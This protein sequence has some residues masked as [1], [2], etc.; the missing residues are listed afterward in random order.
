[1][2]AAITLT[3]STLIAAPAATAGT[4]AG[5]TVSHLRAQIRNSRHSAVVRARWLGILLHVGNA[6]QHTTSVSYL[7]WM[8]NAW[9]RRAAAYWD[10]LSGRSGVYQAL[11]CI[12]RHEGAWTAYSAAGPYYGGLQM[13]ES[14]MAH[15]GSEYLA[16]FG[17]ARHWPHGLQVAAAYRAVRQLG[18]SPWPVSSQ[19]C[20]L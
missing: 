16:L 4:S 5:S 17:D 7:T 13:D 14:F 11:L 8:R 6:E 18:Y 20:G 1:M 10:V 19:A 2:L 12:H 9:R 3:A 15:W